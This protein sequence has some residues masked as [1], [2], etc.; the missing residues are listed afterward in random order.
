M[1]RIW[2]LACSIAGFDGGDGLAVFGLFFFVC[3]C[4]CVQAKVVLALRPPVWS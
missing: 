1:G 4:V 3:V 2:R